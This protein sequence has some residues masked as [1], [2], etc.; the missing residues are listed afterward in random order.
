MLWTPVDHIHT[1]MDVPSPSKLPFWDADDCWIPQKSQLLSPVVLVHAFF[2]VVSG[3]EVLYFKEHYYY[4]YWSLLVTSFFF[5]KN[6]GSITAV[7][8][9]YHT[10]P[11]HILLKFVIAL[12][13]SLCYHSL[14][15][16][17]LKSNTVF[18]TSI[19][20]WK[21]SIVFMT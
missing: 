5:P 2:S 12:Y 14:W 11:L 9:L 17:F 18:T 1:R 15:T 7:G 20:E 8:L 6:D 3:F 21:H 13:P 10:F 4:L 16:T 19:R